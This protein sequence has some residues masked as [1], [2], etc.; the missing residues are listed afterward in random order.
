MKENDIEA[1]EEV[2]VRRR[3]IQWS[4]FLFDIRDIHRVPLEIH[5]IVIF[6]STFY[7]QNHVYIY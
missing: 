7:A 6:Q 2:S 1:E 5:H 4:I 3:S